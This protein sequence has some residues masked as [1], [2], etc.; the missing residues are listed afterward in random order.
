MF[1]GSEIP[2]AAWTGQMIYRTDTQELQVF[3]GEAWEDVVGGQTGLLTFVGSDVPVSVNVGDIWFNTTTN[4]TYRAAS[5]GADVVNVGEWELVIGA[6]QYEVPPGS[7]TADK[8]ASVLL[9]NSRIDVGEIDMTG[10]RPGDQNPNLLPNITATNTAGSY[11]ASWYF[12]NGGASEIT[13]TPVD[14]IPTEDD[15]I[16]S[17]FAAQ[18]YT[19]LQIK[20]TAPG[21]AV[22]STRAGVLATTFTVESSTEY[23]MSVGM[24]YPGANP[25]MGTLAALSDQA[26][27]NRIR[28]Q[29]GID[30]TDTTLPNAPIIWKSFYI[31]TTPRPDWMQYEDAIVKTG[32]T[33]TTLHVRIEVLTNLS[34]GTANGAYL[35]EPTLR[36]VVTNT[37]TILSPTTS[38]DGTTAPDPAATGWK[39]V[40][41]WTAGT[42]TTSRA[43]TTPTLGASFGPP[44]YGVPGRYARLT[45]TSVFRSCNA[46]GVTSSS[47]ATATGTLTIVTPAAVVPDMS[48]P[49]SRLY[50]TWGFGGTLSST[51]TIT[52]TAHYYNDADVFQSAVTVSTGSVSSYGF[53]S[54]TENLWTARLIPPAAGTKVVFVLQYV[55]ISAAAG[56][57]I[58]LRLQGSRL[59]S[60]E[61]VNSNYGQM[62]GQHVEIDADGVRMLNKLGQIQVDIPT[63]QNSISTFKGDVEAESLR[64]L[65]GTSFE[66]QLNEIAKDASLSLSAGIKSP[67]ATPSLVQEYEQYTMQRTP[68]AGQHPGFSTPP[69]LNPSSITGMCWKSEWNELWLMENRGGGSALWRYTTGGTCKWAGLQNGWA[70][71]TPYEDT[72]TTPGVN[73]NLYAGEYAGVHWAQVWTGSAQVF[74]KIP[75]GTI[76]S[77]IKAQFTW[78]QSNNKLYIWYRHSD[79]SGRNV[80]KRMGVNNTNNGEMTLEETVV[81]GAGTAPTGTNLAGAHIN[82]STIYTIARA[83]TSVQVYA[84]ATGSAGALNAGARWDL[85]ANSVGFCYDGTNYWAV[86]TSGR[87]TKYSTWTWSETNHKI[88]AGISWYD[89]DAAGTGTHETDVVSLTSATLKKRISSI[90]LT[91]PQVP[92]KGGTD[93]PTHWRLYMAKSA[94][95]TLPG[96]R[97]SLWL[98]SQGGSASG[99]TS[100]SVPANG[101]ITSGTNPPAA[102]NFPGAG[103]GKIIS[104]ATDGSSNPLIY[105]DGAGLYTLG[106]TSTKTGRITTWATVSAFSVANAT[107]VPDNGGWTNIIGDHT[108]NDGWVGMVYSGGGIWTCTEKGLYQFEIGFNWEAGGASTRRWLLAWHNQTTL[109]DTTNYRMRAETVVSGNLQSILRFDIK[110]AVNDTIRFGYRQDSG[111]A[112]G[113]TTSQGFN[114]SGSQWSR[115]FQVLRKA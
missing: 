20:D 94:A 25:A 56:T 13:A 64:I 9:L 58:T 108:A 80:Y 2:E 60:I 27:C 35:M 112:I 31:P 82:G 37:P 8:F 78:N 42:P 54:L 14:F 4:E 1:A 67:V 113:A 46:T 44:P 85:A 107:Y 40:A 111:A 19:A 72:R 83:T 101:L 86:D 23:R 90:R 10:L 87:L 92:D 73:D 39:S 99:Q 76:P 93:D 38:V 22:S 100:Y 15:P 104:A 81:G 66:S 71:T 68:P 102:N 95:I 79:G 84:F 91:L 88:Y 49:T 62:L 26:N 70:W 32:S 11:D 55:G 110:L 74:N 51:G 53:S 43:T 96:S 77:G 97:T 29:I 98:Q 16:R 115:Y 17:R 103:A 41:S 12:T 59:F 34:L 57:S 47:N 30:N 45:G 65:G 5:V 114:I 6:E 21:G 50:Y 24:A 106:E 18:T 52:L 61:D 105:F 28:V 109:N 7:I 36:K 69:T 3:N 48:Q 63:D 89:S 75:A 33:Q